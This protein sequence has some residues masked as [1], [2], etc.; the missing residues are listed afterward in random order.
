MRWGRIIVGAFI[1]EVLL[2]I[3]AVPIF[4]IGGQ[5]MLDWTAVIGSAVTSFV[6]AMWVCRRVESRFV[7]HGA[8]TGFTAAVI[9]VAL[10]V[11]SGQ[12]QPLIYWVAHGLKIVG[13]A[14]GGLLAAQRIANAAVVTHAAARTGK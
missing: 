14:A 3:V 12:T 4:S 1:A 13:G 5:T 7:L 2:I 6:A 10:I 11:A 9:Y 8:L